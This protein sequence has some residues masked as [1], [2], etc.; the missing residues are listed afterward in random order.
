MQSLSKLAHVRMP[1]TSTTAPTM[2]E[3]REVPAVGANGGE[4]AHA[5]GF[6]IM[7]MTISTNH[8]RCQRVETGRAAFG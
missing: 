8:E 6:Q 5:P 3:E 1:P 2:D 4:D 7:S